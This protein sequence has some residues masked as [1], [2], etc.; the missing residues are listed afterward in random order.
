MVAAVAV[1][2]VRHGEPACSAIEAELEEVLCDS[3]ALVYFARSSSILALRP[4]KEQW[5]TEAVREIELRAP[6]PIERAVRV[7][8]LVS[9][10]T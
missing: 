8:G 6:A 3:K 2:V 5:R 10:A 7:A 9:I 4:L 1:A